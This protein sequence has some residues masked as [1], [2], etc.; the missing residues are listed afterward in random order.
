MIR[1]INWNTKFFEYISEL[2]EVLF[3][4]KINRIQSSVSMSNAAVVLAFHRLYRSNY[5]DAKI[6]PEQSSRESDLYAKKDRVLAISL[7]YLN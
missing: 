3:P 1:L 4:Y 5:I 2:L 6:M 7:R